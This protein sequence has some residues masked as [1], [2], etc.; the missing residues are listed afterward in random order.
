[1]VPVISGSAAGAG[2]TIDA[3]GAGGGAGASGGRGVATTAGERSAVRWSDAGAGAS[4]S[5]IGSGGSGGGVAAGAATVGGL[6]RFC[7]FV[8]PT[9]FTDAGGLATAAGT[10]LAGANGHPNVR[11]ERAGCVTV[12]REPAAGDGP[13]VLGNRLA[14]VVVAASGSAGAAAPVNSKTASGVVANNSQRRTLGIPCSPCRSRDF[15]TR[16]K[17]DK[18]VRIPERVRRPTKILRML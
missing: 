10:A 15:H 5:A 12:R 13:A 16:R 4:G 18:R 17:P 3:G 14:V 9:D 6:G 7:C 11:P 8:D 2:P 1:V